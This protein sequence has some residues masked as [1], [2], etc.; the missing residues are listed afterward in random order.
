M[1]VERL[2]CGRKWNDIYD[3]VC[4]VAGIVGRAL[5]CAWS[6]TP[7]ARC[8]NRVVSLWVRGCGSNGVGD[9][10]VAKARCLHGVLWYRDE[11]LDCPRY[12][13]LDSDIDSSSYEFWRSMESMPSAEKVA[14]VEKLM[15]EVWGQCH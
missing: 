15:R 3:R 12:D 5:V 8:C 10:V 4:V 7:D 1:R 14:L 13:S 11:C 2:S 6:A 9:G